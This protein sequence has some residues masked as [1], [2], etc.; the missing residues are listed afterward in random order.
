MILEK[1]HLYFP[2]AKTREDRRVPLLGGTDKMLA[3]LPRRG[4]LVLPGFADRTAR[5]R[6][7]RHA[8]AKVGL[9]QWLCKKCGVT[10]VKMKCPE[11]G[12]LSERAA[13]YKG[14]LLRYTRT[15]AIRNLTNRGVPIQRI[16]QMTGHKNVPTH[17]GYNI[18]DEKDLAL[19]RKLYD[20]K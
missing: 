13:K 8:A 19:I 6:A 5:A 14:P 18:A 3:K 4:E 15:T 9:G 16:M 17:M 12:A 10:L 11:H 7:W 20:E 2:S 1:Q